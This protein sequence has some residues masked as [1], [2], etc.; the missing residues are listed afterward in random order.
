MWVRRHT[1]VGIVSAI[2]ATAVNCDQ[3]PAGLANGTRCGAFKATADEK[4][5]RSPPLPCGTAIGQSRVEM[6]TQTI[7]RTAR[8]GAAGLTLAL[9]IASAWAGPRE[10]AKRIHD[11]LAGVPP[12][13]AVLDTM[14]AQI[15]GGNAIA[16]A[17]TAMQNS[18]FYSVTLKNWATPW[19]NRDGDIF[20]PLNDYTATVIGMIRDDVPFNEVLFGDHLYV[21]AAG[22]GIPGYSMTNND[23]YEALEQ[24][25]I[26][27]QANLVATTQSAQ[28]DLPAAATAGVM[29]TRAAAEA[30]FIAG[31]NRA[32]LRFTLMNHLCRDLEQVADVTRPPDRIRQDVTRSP[33]G[34]SR[35]FLGNCISCHSGMD[36]LAQAFAYYNY[37]E[38]TGR[39][40]YTD[41]AVHPK[42]FN[43]DTNFPFGFRTP[44]DSWSNY[45]RDGRNA[46]LGW[47][48]AQTGT[49]QG[50]KSMGRELA[51][52]Q[53]F[54]QCQV[55][56]VF[57][58]VCLRKPGDAADR[59]Q[60]DAMTA[61]LV[62]SNYRLKTTFAEAATYC[63]GD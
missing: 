33:G 20:A 57:E 56:K 24:N 3:T 60:V 19:T 18:A 47:D 63:M 28:T 10:Q 27:L 12:T 55:E 22:L 58:N 13:A 40:E 44:D 5:T 32:M 1:S 29:T 21:G 43:N 14:E 45:W 46:L 42:Y 61:S 37:N 62:G 17:E 11:R 53:A 50:A 16:A 35:L 4:R 49:G 30:F 23:H 34:D 39:I 51:G 9:S 25:A 8:L 6:N 41:G 15:A 2:T 52:S 54:A 26:D 38:E 7:S 36:P 48:P 59:A 31:T